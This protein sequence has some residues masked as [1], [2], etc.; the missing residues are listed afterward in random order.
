MITIGQVAHSL[1]VHRCL[2]LFDEKKNIQLLFETGIA[3]LFRG[4]EM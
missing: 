3:K 2:F 4:Y 1:I